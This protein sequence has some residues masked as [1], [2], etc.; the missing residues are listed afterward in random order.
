L[1]K[2]ETKKIIP[3]SPIF[4]TSHLPAPIELSKCLSAVAN[5]NWDNDLTFHLPKV[6]MQMVE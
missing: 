2:K 4:W 3:D 1:K 5:I 6:D